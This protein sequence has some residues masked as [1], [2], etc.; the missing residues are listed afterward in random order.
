MSEIIVPGAGIIV[1]IVA[2]DIS[3][4]HDVTGADINP[5]LF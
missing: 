3:K 2:N 1:S 4:N 5:E